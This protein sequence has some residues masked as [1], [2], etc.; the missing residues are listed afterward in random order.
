VQ[1]LYQGKPLADNLVIAFNR[2]RP[3][4]K[5]RLQTDADGRARLR[6]SRPGAWLV[7][8][9]HLMPAS[10]FSRAD[11]ESLWASLTFEVP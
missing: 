2:D 7:T 4:D 9:V 5:Q 11:W 3:M 1:L 8:S 10:L 6:L